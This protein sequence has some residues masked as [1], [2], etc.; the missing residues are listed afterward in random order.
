VGHTDAPKAG[1]V[2]KQW[3]SDTQITR[4][5]SHTYA[6]AH[7]C[8]CLHTKCAHTRIPTPT[9]YTLTHAHTLPY[10]CAHPTCVHANVGTPARSCIHLMPMRTHAHTQTHAL[11]HMLTHVCTHFCACACTC[12]AHM[13]SQKHTCAHAHSSSTHT[14]TCTHPH[15]PAHSPPVQRAD[16]QYMARSNAET[17][18]TSL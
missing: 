1:L 11:M 10:I 12:P 2:W 17:G 15:P 5:H 9:S 4:V 8:T 3:P 14:R 16:R 6:Q 7:T 13:H 18:G